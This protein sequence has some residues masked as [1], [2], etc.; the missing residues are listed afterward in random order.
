MPIGTCVCT[1]MLPSQTGSGCQHTPTFE[2]SIQFIYDT[3]DTW[4]N[5]QQQ[6]FLEGLDLRMNTMREKN[7]QSN[8]SS[9]Q[10]FK[11][12]QK[13]FSP[14]QNFQSIATVSSVSPSL[15]EFSPFV[16]FLQ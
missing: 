9:H 5:S 2:E 4:T 3:F 8:A 13:P 11:N 1:A 15:A 16:D 6:R 14:T 10:N 12:S 7:S